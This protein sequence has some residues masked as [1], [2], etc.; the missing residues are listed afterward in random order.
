MDAEL[1]LKPQV[2][3]RIGRC[4]E[5]VVV[6]EINPDRIDRG[7]LAGR[8]RHQYDLVPVAEQLVFATRPLDPEVKREVACAERHT[9]DPPRRGQDFRQIRQPLR[10]FDDRD[11]VNAAAFEA[12]FALKLRHEPVGGLNLGSRFDFRKNHAIKARVKRFHEIAVRERRRQWIHPHV[13]E[14]ASGQLHGLNHLGSA[15]DLLRY[16][17]G[18]LKIKNDGIRPD[19]E[20][21][22]SASRMV[23]RC[24]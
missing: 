16:R 5:T 19:R 7:L 13:A 20:R 24:E 22:F 4:Q 6:L 11:Q 10:G 9:P 17:T 1:A 21:L 15:G 18:I 23:G 3:D 14:T 8:A 2:P 12:A